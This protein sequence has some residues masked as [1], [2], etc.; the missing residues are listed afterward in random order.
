MGPA[1]KSTPPTPGG[2]ATVTTAQGLYG[3]Y[4]VDPH[5]RTLYLFDADPPNQSTC[6]ASCA[7]EHPPLVAVGAPA[8]GDGTNSNLLDVISRPD[9]TNQV[10]YGG[11]PLYY[12]LGDTEPDDTK[13]QGVESKWWMVTPQARAMSTTGASS[14]P[15]SG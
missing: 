9:G 15:A 10:S 1:P 14:A 3:D 7:T 13:G 5:G 12:F 2:D 11:H 4:L 6:L 8:A